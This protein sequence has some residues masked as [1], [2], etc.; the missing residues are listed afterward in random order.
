MYYGKLNSIDEN[1]MF[2]IIKNASRL[3]VETKAIET[4]YN[5]GILKQVENIMKDPSHPLYDQYVFLRSGRRL[6]I[7]VPHTDRYR[8]SFVPKS[9]KSYNYLKTVRS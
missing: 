8:K 5:E 1:K 6:A 3:G 7:P 2:R 9:I 4:L